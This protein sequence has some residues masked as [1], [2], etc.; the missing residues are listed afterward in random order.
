[1]QNS[2]GKT[3]SVRIKPEYV[4]RVERVS[5]ALSEMVGGEFGNSSVLGRA[6]EL[7]LPLLEARLGIAPQLVKEPKAA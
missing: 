4:A 7:G 6:Y 5:K 1:M 3:T 2:R